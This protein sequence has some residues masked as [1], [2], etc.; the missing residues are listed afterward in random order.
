M[1]S[2]NDSRVHG[3]PSS[4]AR[5][6]TRLTNV[7]SRTNHSSLSSGPWSPQVAQEPYRQSGELPPGHVVPP[8][9]NGSKIPTSQWLPAGS[10]SDPPPGR[11]P[12]VAHSLSLDRTTSGECG[13]DPM[14][15]ESF[16]PG[17]LC[18][19]ND[20]HSWPTIKSRSTFPRLRRSHGDLSPTNLLLSWGRALRTAALFL[21]GFYV[22]N[23]ILENA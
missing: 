2:E 12:L 11:E 16:A 15:R 5:P 8:A 17:I 6:V 20:L 14:G 22:Q 9:G 21:S 1:N 4:A 19:G 18:P 23:F 7:Y 10:G 13:E 3:Q